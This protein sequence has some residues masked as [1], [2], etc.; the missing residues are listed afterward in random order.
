M[1]ILSFIDKNVLRVLKYL[2]HTPGVW[3]NGLPYSCHK[4]L[5][6]RLN[7]LASGDEYIYFIG[8]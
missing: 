3:S 5:V 2:Y 7:L 8:C 4:R 6:R 1:N